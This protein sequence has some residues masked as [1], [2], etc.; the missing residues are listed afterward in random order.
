[1]IAR[2]RSRPF[3]PTDPTAP[4]TDPFAQALRETEERFRFL[5]DNVPV[6][7]WT[8][9]PDGN[10]D[11]V[12]EQTAQKLGLTPQKLLADGWQNVLHP[13]DLPLAIE[14]WTHALTTGETYE[15]E[16]RLKLADGNWAWHLA[17]AIPQR[18]EA[19]Q[20]VRWFGTNTNIEEQREQRSL[21]ALEAEIGIA[22]TR[23]VSLGETLAACAEALVRH[24][25]ASFARIWTVDDAGKILE[26]RA[27]A[28]LYTHLDG[29][30]G[31]VPI[32]KFKIGQIAADRKPHHTNQVVGDP[33]VGDQEWAAREGMVAFA[34]Y[35]IL[36]GSRLLGVVAAFAKHPFSISGISALESVVN[37]LAS[38]IDR[39]KSEAERERLLV[40]AEEARIRAELANRA[41]DEFLATASHEL[42]TPLNAILGWSRLLKEGFLDAAK[43]ARAIE[44]IERNANAQVQLIEDILDGSRIITGKLHLEVRSVDLTTVINAALDAVRPSAAAKNI[45]LQVALDSS[46]ARIK[47]DPDRLQQVVWNLMNNAIKFTPKG[48]SIDVSLARVGTSI[49]LAVKDSGQGIPADFLPHVFERFRQADATTT[50]RH[51]G[52]GLGLALVRHLAEAHGGTVRAESAGVGLGSKFVVVLPVQAVRDDANAS[53]AAPNAAPPPARAIRV[54][55]FA[56][57]S[58]L[59]VDDEPDARD[60]VA[61]VLRLRG[62]EVTTAGSAEEAMRVLELQTPTILLSDIGMPVADGYSLIARVRALKDEN[63]KIP[64]IALTAYAREE[65]RRRAL[66]A[67]FQTYLAKPVEPDSLV[68]AVFELTVGAGKKDPVD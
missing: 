55:M 10:L 24:L 44:T 31:R 48:G 42:R 63:H 41:K 1:M 57:V 47:G 45:S 2:V 27:S 33:R 5:A 40:L 9:L 7:I 36:L 11:Y 14:K 4:A 58:A 54:T 37:G 17:R 28:G 51:G 6:Q 29:P 39:L 13:D 53:S 26:L 23:S 22:V 35:P 18:N 21:L 68:H 8:S 62:A 61:T 60:L 50:R 3:M 67:G 25:D 38:V 66:E 20:I 15:V 46:A 32:G 16:F 52:L 65:D 64:A 19:G 59:V 49:E 30:H 34:G 12:T 43:T 56:N